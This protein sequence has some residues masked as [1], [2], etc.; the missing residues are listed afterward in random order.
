MVFG[1]VVGVALAPGCLSTTSA[2][3]TALNPYPHALV[4]R[5]PA[6]VEVFSSAAP[7]RPHVD[8][9]LI[10][11]EEG[12]TGGGTPDELLGLLRQTAAERGCDAVVVAPPGSKSG[13]DPLL[14]LTR[15]YRVYSGTCIVYT[16]TTAKAPP[17]GP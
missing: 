1:A 2:D 10:T 8:V 4:A 15:S 13:T 17:P 11:V 5:A 14:N 3:F 12:Q 7:A 16:V 6:Q 9:G